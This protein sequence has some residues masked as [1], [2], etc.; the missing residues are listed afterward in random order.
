VLQ[1][2][3]RTLGAL[4]DRWSTVDPTVR[5][6]FSPFEGAVDLNDLVALQL[7]AVL[8]MEGKGEPAGIT[9]LK[10]ELR[11]IGDDSVATGAWLATAMSASWDLRLEQLISDEIGDDLDTWVLD[12]PNLVG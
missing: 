10:R 2:H 4:A 11:E 1:R 3:A 5:D 6:V 7:E 8:F 9:H 12:R